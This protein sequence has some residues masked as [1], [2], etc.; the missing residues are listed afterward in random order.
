MNGT[1]Y[2]A[3]LNDG[4]QLT[5]LR[6]GGGLNAQRIDMREHFDMDHAKKSA[7]HA[8]DLEDTP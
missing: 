1:E 8:A 7:L 4:R 2:L 3:S 5:H 6:F